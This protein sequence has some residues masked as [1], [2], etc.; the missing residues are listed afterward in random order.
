MVLTN[1][2]LRQFVR[3]GRGSPDCSKQG[4]GWINGRVEVGAGK[5]GAADCGIEANGFGVIYSMRNTARSH[6]GSVPEYSSASE[7]QPQLQGGSI[8]NTP[9][10]AGNFSSYKN[11]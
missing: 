1:S 3:S 7:G 8:P 4:A 9:G 5:A 11:K 6:T 2:I 10:K